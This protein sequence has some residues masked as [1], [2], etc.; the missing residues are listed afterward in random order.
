MERYCYIWEFHVHLERQAEFERCYGPEG[1]W[2][3]L[4]RQAPG[5]VETLLL[6]DRSQNLRYV[7]ID[8]WESR[9]TYRD[10]RSQFSRQYEELDQL[11]QGLTTHE[12][13]LGEF[14]Y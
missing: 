3:A 11:C 9:E 2:V 1:A 10:F 6:Q 13:P 14:S 8:R 5:Y 7:T 4:F 12:A